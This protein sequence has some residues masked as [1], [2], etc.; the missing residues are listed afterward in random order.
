MGGCLEGVGRLSKGCGEAV[1]RVSGG[2][3]EGV[4][5]YFIGYRDYV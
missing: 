3:L 2:C 5:R 1:W 4:G